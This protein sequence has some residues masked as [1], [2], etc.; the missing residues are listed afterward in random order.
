MVTEIPQ[1]VIVLSGVTTESLV[2]YVKIVINL[3]KLSCD[4]NVNVRRKKQEISNVIIFVCLF[5]VVV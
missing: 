2:H 4:G 3:F 1:S 5:F